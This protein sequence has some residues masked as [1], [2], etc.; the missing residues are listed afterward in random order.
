[1]CYHLILVLFHRLIPTSFMAG[2]NTPQAEHIDS[3]KH[4]GDLV[5][6]LSDMSHVSGAD[7]RTISID[8][9][10]EPTNTMQ[11]HTAER[12]GA[13]WGLSGI[14]M[15]LSGQLAAPYMR[16]FSKK[17]EIS[18]K[19]DKRQKS[20]ACPS[21]NGNPICNAQQPRQKITESFLQCSKAILPPV[22]ADNTAPLVVFI[23][24]SFHM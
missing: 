9:Y 5:L 17:E 2:D 12:E 3:S 21:T 23:I 13:V 18:S 19:L 24:S 22:S 16:A 6:Q 1:M 8:E 14:S 10:L 15:H 20:E 4:E 7:R 11:L